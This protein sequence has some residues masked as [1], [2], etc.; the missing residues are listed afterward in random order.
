MVPAVLYIECAYWTVSQIKDIV[1]PKDVVAPK[2]AV[3]PKDAVGPVRDVVD[4]AELRRLRNR[5]RDMEA[6]YIR[7]RDYWIEQLG[8]GPMKQGLTGPRIK[9]RWNSFA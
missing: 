1:A 2:D 5:L 9:R 7:Q 3:P 4:S 8:E 6:T